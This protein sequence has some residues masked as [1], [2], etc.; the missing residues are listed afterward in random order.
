[1]ESLATRE[2]MWNIPQWMKIVMYLSL[3]VSLA[4]MMKG[5]NQKLLFVTGGEGFKGIKKLLPEKLNWPSFINTIFFTGKVPRHPEVGFFHSLIFYGFVILWIATDIVAIHY[6][7][8]LKIFHGTTYIIISFLADFAGLAIL[9]GLALAYKRRY[10]S[11]PK[12]LEATQPKRELFMYGMLASLVIVGYLIEGLR[13]SGTGM[14]I[15]E[16]TWAPIG[17]ALANLFSSLSLSDSAMALT[18]RTL[19]LYH[20]AN[21]M[22]FVASIGYTKFSHILFLPLSSLIT[23]K[24]R[25]AV[26]NPMN[27]EDE[28]A[29]TFGLA[30]LSELTAKNRMDL[31]SC[32][33]CGRCTLSCPAN[34]AGKPLDPKK[35]ITK[36]RDLFEAQTK[37]GE[38]GGDIW[39]ENP[40]YS[41]NELD[42]CTTCGAC[43]EECPANIE[44]VNIIMEAKRYKALTLGELPPSAADATN[45]IKINGNPWGIS[46]DD[47]FKWADGLEIPI[48]ETGKKVDYLYY[49]GC[50][51]SYDAANQKV[52][53]DTVMLLKKAGVSFAVMGKTEKCNGD[54]VRRFGDE[55]S[56][57]EIAIENIANMKQYTFDKVVTHCPH[58]LH[59]I[60]KE[61]AKF[62]DG[63][64]ETV[65]HTELLADLLKS[66]K[67]KPE[68][69]INQEL[70][71]HDPCYLGRHHGEYDAP[72]AILQAIPGLKLKE[73]EKN[74]DS[75]LCCG[76]GGGN[77]WYELPEGDHLAKKRL[78]HVAE[79]NT[80][81]LA[82][83][84]SFCLINF[85]SSKAQV[86]K[87]E[88]LEVEDVAS[89]LAKSI[90]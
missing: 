52:V 15:G 79:T 26:L 7:T 35:I 71:F 80:P 34:N 88:N 54:P 12:Y 38:N 21:T 24:R 90:Q 41:A 47:R 75:A 61:Y 39:G 72:R 51:G 11:K 83:S 87:T 84:C 78:E 86:E 9:V 29:E 13:I 17:W 48:I 2:I 32:V 55:Y 5:L 65:H 56:F 68:K 42:A 77:M 81:K 50:A 69:A 70:T 85:N 30:N 74:K 64:F 82:T 73:M 45:K 43:M 36:A 27:F 63:Q 67:L 10:I 20:M 46:Q 18:Y 59:T 40:L 44:H 1:M 57:Y 89:L 49:V 58:C 16:K 66:G 60:G 3:F 6:D 23:P 62:D 19:W 37:L 4:A 8:P 53:K 28:S 76:M 14:P 25:G 31:I 22:V 33:E